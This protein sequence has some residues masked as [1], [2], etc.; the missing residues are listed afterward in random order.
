MA[1]LPGTGK[2]TLSRALAREFSGTVLD[3]D[4][5]RAAL[6]PPADIEYSNEQDDFTM[7]V[8]LKT[9]GYL[10]RKAPSRWIFLDGRTFSRRYQLTRATGFATAIGQRWKILE[11]RCRDETARQRL[12]ADPAHPAANRDFAL[13]LEVKARFEEI[14]LPKIIIDTDQPLDRCVALGK[15]GLLDSRPAACPEEASP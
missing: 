11:C 4:T 13:Y 12:L 6:F 5:V 14:T 2:S 10:F 7:A 8:M 9:A 1:G 3:K 15:A